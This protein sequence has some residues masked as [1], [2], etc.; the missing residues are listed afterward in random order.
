MIVDMASKDKAILILVSQQPMSLPEVKSTVN[1][2]KGGGDSFLGFSARSAGG[3]TTFTVSG[4]LDSVWHRMGDVRPGTEI[5][6][7]RDIALVVKEFS[8]VAPPELPRAHP[9]RSAPSG[10][11]DDVGLMLDMAMKMAT[12]SMQ[13]FSGPY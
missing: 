4:E 13:M 3:V 2:L 1:E 11:V 9:Q 12:L 8:V 10:D 7:S 5:K 6:I